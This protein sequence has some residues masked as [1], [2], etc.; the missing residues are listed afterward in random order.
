[1]TLFKKIKEMI[2]NN[3]NSTFINKVKEVKK[4][5]KII[6]KIMTQ[7]MIQKKSYIN[8]KTIILISKMTIENR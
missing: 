2:P 1:M 6:I 3:T 5:Y 7:L 8:R 4:I